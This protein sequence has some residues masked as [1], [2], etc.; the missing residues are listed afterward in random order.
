LVDLAK[1][2]RLQASEHIELLQAMEQV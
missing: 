2:K 1:G